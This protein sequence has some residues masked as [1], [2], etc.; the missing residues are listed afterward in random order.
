MSSP[1]QKRA[2]RRYNKKRPPLCFRDH[3]GLTEMLEGFRKQGE[4]KIDAIKRSIRLMGQSLERTQE[5]D[6]MICQQGYEAA[7]K[8]YRIWIQCCDCEKEID[9]IPN[10]LL[11]KYIIDDVKYGGWGHRHCHVDR[12]Q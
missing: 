12:Y 11:H 5:H 10:S 3:E 8:E 6:D 9:V 7:K 1:A 4:T 2:Q